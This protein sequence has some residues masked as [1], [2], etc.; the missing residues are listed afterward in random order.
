MAA[1]QL[2]RLQFPSISLLKQASGTFESFAPLLYPGVAPLLLLL[3][4]AYSSAGALT[5]NFPG[6]VRRVIRVRA[7]S[8]LGLSDSETASRLHFSKVHSYMMLFSRTRSSTGC[9]TLP[10]L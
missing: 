5:L 2:S 1:V 8:N 4:K 3:T 9:G 6:A 10:E 7:R